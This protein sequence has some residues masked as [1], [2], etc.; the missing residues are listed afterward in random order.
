MTKAAWVAKKFS[1]ENPARGSVLMQ[2]DRLFI[3]SHLNAKVIG[4]A[5]ARFFKLS[6]NKPSY[7]LFAFDRAEDMEHGR[8]FT[9]ARLIARHGDLTISVRNRS[10]FPK[11]DKND[12]K[13]Y[14]EWVRVI[15]RDFENNGPGDLDRARIR[16]SVEYENQMKKAAGHKF[17]LGLE[18][19]DHAIHKCNA[20]LT[21][22]TWTDFSMRI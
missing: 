4:R 22:S 16:A 13:V 15:T 6:I 17:G 11:P 9:L 18:E 14:D 20:Y 1:E 21:C 2:N 12:L 8:G 10:E 19:A 5:L 3:P 7:H